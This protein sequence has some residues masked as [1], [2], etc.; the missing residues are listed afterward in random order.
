[1]PKPHDP[2]SNALIERHV[3]IVKEGA[4]CMLYAAGMPAMCWPWAAKYFCQMRNIQERIQTNGTVLDP[5]YFLRYGVH[6]KGQ[7]IPFGA[8]IEFLPRS[9]FSKDTHATMDVKTIPGIFLGYYEDSHG[10]T[11]DYVVISNSYLLDA[12]VSP[13]DRES[14]RLT[15]QRVG[16]VIFDKSKPPEFAL[17]QVFDVRRESILRTDNFN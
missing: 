4:R 17:K 5:P 13:N 3:R 6:F 11:D 2:Q 12:K 14:W 7:R 9:E 8:L 10:M 16:R 15:P 1:M